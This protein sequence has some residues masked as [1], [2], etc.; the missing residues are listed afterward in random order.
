MHFQGIINASESNV[1]HSSDFVKV[2]LCLTVEQVFNRLLGSGSDDSNSP[3]SPS[4]L[5]IGLHKI[6]STKCEL[7]FIIK[8][9][10]KN[11]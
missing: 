9:P 10:D 7:R 2:I 4:E 3:I 6:D 11:G 5:L 8:G 1:L